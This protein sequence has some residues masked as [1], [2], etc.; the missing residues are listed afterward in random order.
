MY[1]VVSNG[2]SPVFVISQ[3]ITSSLPASASRRATLLDLARREAWDDFI[4]RLTDFPD[5]PL[6]EF[7]AG[8]ESATAAKAKE[9][10]RNDSGRRHEVR[11]ALDVA[12]HWE[13]K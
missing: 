12:R 4:A 13:G 9:K 11:R 10:L 5:E 2:F 7:A 6:W 1:S 3:S 8:T